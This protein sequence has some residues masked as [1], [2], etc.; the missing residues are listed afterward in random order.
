MSRDSAAEA[1]GIGRSWV[2]TIGVSDRADAAREMAPV[3][4]PELAA[5]ELACANAAVETLRH[6]LSTRNRD[7]ARDP[8]R[9]V[10]NRLGIALDETDTDWPRLAFRAL[11]VMLE[12][13]LEKLRNGCHGSTKAKFLVRPKTNCYGSRLPLESQC[14]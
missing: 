9:E 1:A 5:Y 6:A 7:V 12:A 3:R 10:A 13:E 11:R 4:T 8:L 2:D 14:K